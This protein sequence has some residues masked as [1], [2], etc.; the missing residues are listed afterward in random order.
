VS[1][2]TALAAVAVLCLGAAPGL[3]AQEA[4]PGRDH[5]RIAGQAGHA[6]SGR[7][8][9]NQAA[10]SGNAQAN[11][12]VLAISTGGQG[13]AALQVRQHP[14]PGAR[15]RAASTQLQGHAFAGSQ[16]LLS[17]N[18]VA[19]SG[20]AQANLF[21]V[22]QRSVSTPIPLPIAGLDDTALAAVA[23][24]PGPG[25]HATPIPPRD[26]RIAD[27]AFRGSQGVIQLNQ[28]AGV[29]NLSTNAIVLQLPGG[30]P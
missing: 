6:V 22:G 29:G 11:L 27:D 30:T 12:A 16:G 5:A 20:N 3:Q 19:G 15:D 14:A 24:A 25:D 21:V 10:G 23:A 4:S 28:T 7:V 13:Q 17:I 26:A 2:R 1:T 8:A 9:V 18:Q